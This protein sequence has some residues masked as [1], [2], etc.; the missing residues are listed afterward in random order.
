MFES[1]KATQ[2]FDEDN[3]QPNKGEWR[4]VIV[5]YSGRPGGGPSNYKTIIYASPGAVE[6]GGWGILD[7]RWIITGDGDNICVTPSIHCSPGRGIENGEWHG[8]LTDGQ[9][10]GQ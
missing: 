10:I 7:D 4:W 2:I 5:D 1:M 6:N 8:H 9:W 3:Y